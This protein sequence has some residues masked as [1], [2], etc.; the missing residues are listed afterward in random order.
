MLSNS[1]GD[2]KYILGLC[3]EGT[4][5]LGVQR[6][7]PDNY[8]RASRAKAMG[9]ARRQEAE[10]FHEGL[11]SLLGEE[12]AP[13]PCSLVASPSCR[14]LWPLGLGGQEWCRGV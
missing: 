13:P 4:V 9:L 3:Q 2:V 14:D 8:R 1:P 5:A 12:E 7:D 6:G 11:L 10:D